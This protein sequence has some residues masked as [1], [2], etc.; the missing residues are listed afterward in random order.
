ML[1]MLQ[2]ND[3]WGLNKLS[4]IVSVNGKKVDCTLTMRPVLPAVD[5]AGYQRHSEP[6]QCALRVAG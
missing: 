2:A 4:E 5:G 6:A 1:Y 3:P